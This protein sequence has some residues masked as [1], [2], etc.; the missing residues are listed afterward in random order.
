MAFF[1]WDGSAH[2]VLGKQRRIGLFAGDVFGQFQM[3]GPGP[4][5]LG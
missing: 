1:F 2:A 4:L 5:L 3:H